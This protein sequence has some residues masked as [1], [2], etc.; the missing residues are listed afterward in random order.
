M[1]KASFIFFSFAC[2]FDEAQK[3]V[4]PTAITPPRMYFLTCCAFTVPLLVRRKFL[5]LCSLF[6]SIPNHFFE[7]SF[8]RGL[9]F[10]GAFESTFEFDPAL[11]EALDHLNSRRGI[12]HTL[13]AKDFF[14]SR[15]RNRLRLYRL[16]A[17]V[18]QRRRDVCRRYTCLRRKLDD[19]L[20]RPRFKQEGAGACADIFRRDHGNGV[21]DRLEIAVDDAF[22]YGRADIS[23]M[24]FHEPSRSKKRDGH[25]EL[26][27]R[28]LH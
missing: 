11:I 6:A 5:S 19:P 26:P 10:D 27:E 15:S 22:A 18:S 7:D 28:L 17:N 1:V 16:A 21:L 14:P 23:S 8:E 2:A 25:R 3:K 24:V 4:K 20:A 9:L 12:L 13:S